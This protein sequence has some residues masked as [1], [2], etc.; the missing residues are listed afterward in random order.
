MFFGE[1]AALSAAFF[2]AGNSIA[3]TE[4]TVRIGSVAVNISRM[5]MA[6]IYL[7]ITIFF[8]QASFDIS[9]NQYI[10]FVLSGFAGLVLVTLFSLKHF[11]WLDPEL[12]CC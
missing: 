6:S 7:L 1:F 5:F 11:N 12:E 9:I 2:W 4:A 10:L 8:L 3:L